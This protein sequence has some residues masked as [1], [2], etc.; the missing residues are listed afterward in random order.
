MPNYLSPYCPDLSPIIRPLTH[1]TKSDTLFIWV[2]AQDDAFNKAKHLIFT[3]TVLQY[4]D[5]NKPFT[6]PVDASEEGVGSDLLQPIVKTAFNRWHTYQT[7]STQQS[8]DTPKSKK[9]AW[10]FATHLENLTTGSMANRTQKFTPTTSHL[11]SP[12]TSPC[13]KPE[14]GYRKCIKGESF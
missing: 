6:L 2:Q 13:T 8:K 5:L 9:S 10:L 1:L 11:R 7:A 12:I 4:Y 14:H 3:A